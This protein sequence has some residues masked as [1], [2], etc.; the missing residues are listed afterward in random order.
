MAT[1]ITRT[2][3]KILP[4]VIFMV[5]IAGWYLAEETRRVGGP[6]GSGNNAE[7]DFEIESMLR[8]LLIP[9]LPADWCG[10]E[11]GH[12]LTGNPW[13]W[14]V[15]PNDGTSDFLRGS[16][17]SAISVGLLYEHQPV[18][19]IVNVPLKRDLFVWAAGMKHIQKNHQEIRND[20]RGRVLCAHSRVIMSMGAMSK[21][22]IN[23]ALCA[24][25]K[26]QAMTSI[27]HRLARVA[28]GEGICAIS[29]SPVSAHD[30]VAGHAL[31]IG[32]G[33]VLVDELG[34][35][36]TYL[37]MD[38]NNKLAHRC[39]GGAPRACAALS[40]RDWNKVFE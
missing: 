18:L 1:D 34:A 10:E 26:F 36:I 33:G 15:D 24:P 25:G 16:K 29:L 28:A 13:C 32:A 3:A 38:S 12:S 9:I 23:A 20:L 11:T 19:G 8:D 39:F 37:K 35:P 22:V 31:L 30:L 7:V 21:P 5:G 40:Q 14:V 6:R 27:A 2:L 4:D 17:E